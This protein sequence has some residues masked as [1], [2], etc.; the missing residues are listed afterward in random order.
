MNF[1]FKHFPITNFSAY[2]EK[3]YLNVSR[4]IPECCQ[5]AEFGP[6]QKLTNAIHHQS[7]VLFLARCSSNA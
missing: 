1:G 5:F 6:V 7:T 4:K 2:F 3:F